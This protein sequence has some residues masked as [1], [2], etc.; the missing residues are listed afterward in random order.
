M[1]LFNAFSRNQKPAPA[2][3]HPGQK[4][5]ALI[6][7]LGILLLVTGLA[8]VA[9][10]TSD[11]DR[12]IASNN[13][14]SS[15]AYYAAEA[16]IIRATSMLTDSLWRAGYTNATVGNSFYTVQV[17]DSN[18][19]LALKDSIILN[20]FGTA[21]DSSRS[22]I[23]VLM[24]PWRRPSFKWAAFGD[25]GVKIN[26]GSFIDSYNSDSGTYATQALNGP[27]ARGNLFATNDGDV[28][29]NSEIDIGNNSSIH[30]DVMTP[31][32]VQVGG[33]TSIYG[34]TD[35]SAPSTSLPPITTT[36]M[37]YAK[38]V[39]NAPAGLTLTGGA[40]Y[41]TVTKALTINNKGGT[42]TL[43][44]GV[45]YF[46]SVNFLSGSIAIAPGA[47][48]TIYTD[49]IWN[50]SAGS[51]VNTSLSA[52]N[53]L[54]YSTGPSVTITGG[55]F[56]YAAFYAPNAL[57]TVNGNADVSGS[58]IGKSVK[59]TGGGRWHYDRALLNANRNRQKYLKVAWQ[60]L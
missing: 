7:V 17:I 12:Q 53:L 55:S 2:A 49:G 3:A 16:G 11:T 1:F 10:N 60:V 51:I 59:S 27:D 48:V 13:L 46:S 38:S 8:L 36:E 33:G 50:T 37:N 34:A 15:R 39:S 18:T 28:G 29:S 5:F 45:Y 47:N 41:D 44:S 56:M 9:F 42:I 19:N 32:T 6:V 57:I 21:T 40:A 4:G 54:V 23:K 25:T 31:D 58:F 52:T 43:S 14:G 24:A 30:G 26:G 22:Q 20:S 35:N